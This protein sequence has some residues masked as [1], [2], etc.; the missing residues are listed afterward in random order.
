MS[1]NPK[2]HFLDIL[3]IFSRDMSQISSN[4]L[5]KAF[6]TLQL[7]LMAFLTTNIAFYD[8]FARACTEI[9]IQV[10]FF[11]RKWPTS[12]GFSVF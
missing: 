10:C 12:L 2:M 9:K 7:K 3:E 4:L 8:I 11:R 1:T 5:K 6:A